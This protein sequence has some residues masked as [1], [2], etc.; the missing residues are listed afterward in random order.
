MQ[1]ADAHLL[2]QLAAGGN[3]AIRGLG[4]SFSRMGLPAAVAKW[5]L[6][7]PGPSRDER[8]RAAVSKSVV[9]QSR[10]SEGAPMTSGLPR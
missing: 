5:W 6:S 4:A 9:G 7:H 2:A 3:L 8:A 1:T 10:H